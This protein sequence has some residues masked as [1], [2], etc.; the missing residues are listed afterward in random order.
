MPLRPELSGEA[1]LGGLRTIAVRRIEQLERKFIRNADVQ[2][3]DMKFMDEYAEL[4]HMAPVP[5]G[6][7]GKR[8]SNI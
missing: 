3:D 8:V 4:S 7:D 2:R 5:T 6:W 1:S